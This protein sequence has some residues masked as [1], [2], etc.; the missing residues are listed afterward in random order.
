MKITK[1]NNEPIYR[2]A[3]E[4]IFIFAEIKEANEIILFNLINTQKNWTLL[5]PGHVAWL[6]GTACPI[7]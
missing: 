5:I 6:T 2:V 4:G 3:D 1:G 7:D